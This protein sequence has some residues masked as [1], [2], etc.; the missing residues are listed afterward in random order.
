MSWNWIYT[1][2]LSLMVLAGTGAVFSRYGPVQLFSLSLLMRW[3]MT[4]YLNANNVTWSTWIFVGF[5]IFGFITAWFLRSNT[6]IVGPH[7]WLFAVMALD[8]L[9]VPA[10]LISMFGLSPRSYVL[11]IN[12]CYGLM[13]LVTAYAAW[14]RWLK[15]LSMK[16]HFDDADEGRDGDDS[17]SRRD[18]S[19]PLRYSPAPADRLYDRLF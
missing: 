15:F 3:L 17:L 14:T 4:L 13:I 10:H 8:I 16:N 11:W 7:R 5:S 1:L 18:Q 19:E 6:Q 9:M 2:F 12:I